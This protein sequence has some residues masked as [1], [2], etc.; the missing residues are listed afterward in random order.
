MHSRRFWKF[1]GKINVQNEK[2]VGEVGRLNQTGS[3]LPLLFQ[4]A[5]QDGDLL[6]CHKIAKNNEK[7]KGQI[8]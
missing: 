5:E 2:L 7:N 4:A 1:R 6:I 8:S 3:K